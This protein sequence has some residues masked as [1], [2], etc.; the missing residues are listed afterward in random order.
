MLFLEIIIL[1]TH[2]NVLNEK[3]FFL[4]ATNIFTND[5]YPFT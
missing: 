3:H 5:K 1:T 2:K 4:H